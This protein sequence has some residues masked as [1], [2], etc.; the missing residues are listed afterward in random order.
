MLEN[1][2]ITELQEFMENL[3][4]LIKTLD[5]DED[6]EENRVLSKVAYA[7]FERYQVEYDRRTADKDG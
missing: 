4:I 3:E 1:H 5:K 2:T 7:A 6:N